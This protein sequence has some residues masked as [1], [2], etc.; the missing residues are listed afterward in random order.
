MPSFDDRTLAGRSGRDPAQRLR[1]RLRAMPRLEV[2]ETRCLMSG[3]HPRAEHYDVVPLP[4][5]G[6]A[7]ATQGSAIQSADRHEARPSATQQAGDAGWAQSGGYSGPGT[8]VGGSEGSATALPTI[9]GL[10]RALYVVIPETNISHQSLATAQSLPDLP[11]FGVVGTTAAGEPLDVYRLTLASAAASLDFG[12]VSG[13]PAS[14]APVQIQLFDGSGQVLG[15]W[16][17]GS[18]GSP[19]V[20]AGLGSLPAG[21]TLY[22][23]ITA[24]NAGGLTGASPAIDYQLWVSHPSA[25]DRAPAAPGPGP[26]LPASAISPLS[27][28]PLP[29]ATAPGA[30]AAR[31]D[32]QAAPP[33]ATPN[34]EGSLRV[35][36]GPPALRSARPSEGHFA[37]GDPVPAVASDFNAVVNREWDEQSRTG[38]LSVSRPADGA[39]PAQ[40]SGR[41]HAPDALVLIH[42]PGGFPLLGAVALGHRRRNPAR[43]RDVPDLATLADRP[44]ADRPDAAGLGLGLAAQGLPSGSDDRLVPPT[45]ERSWR[46][47]PVSVF[48]AL[49]VA[50][51]F[52]LNAVLSQ[53]I[54]GFD[55]LTRRLDAD[56]RRRSPGRSGSSWAGSGTRHP[57]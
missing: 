26:S 38:P 49:G 21:S 41:E 28:A 16:S 45:R 13:Q 57:R 1:P 11:Y 51:V 43:G 6:R 3:L 35:A 7:F 15:E 8:G 2:L 55:Y 42:G 37:D 32:S 33:A 36:V 53:P 47:F 54:A 30:V 22:F 31:G 4:A 14:A 12:L 29:G 44:S 10:P 39:E 40:P 18:Q 25:T 5:R 24:G 17:V 20:H 48:S 23:G 9:P 34:Q 46:G 50:T 19:S 56:S 52:T 27:A